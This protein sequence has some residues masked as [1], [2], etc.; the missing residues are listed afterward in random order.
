MIAVLRIGP[1]TD[2]VVYENH[3]Q[4][5]GL[6]LT[7]GS[8]LT[9]A[10]SYLKDLEVTTL[11]VLVTPVVKT[12]FKHTEDLPLFEIKTPNTSRTGYMSI[13]DLKQVCGLAYKLNIKEVEIF[14]L[15][16]VFK[17]LAR[18]EPCIVVGRYNSSNQIY[19]LYLDKNG[20]KD[21]H[22]SKQ[23]TNKNV[24]DL[25]AKH[26]TRR[27]INEYNSELIGR[28]QS[29]FTNL[30]Q[31][32]DKD[33]NYLYP[34]MLT[35]LIEPV[36]VAIPTKVLKIV[37]NEVDNLKVDDMEIP[38]IDD[39]MLTEEE[40]YSTYQEQN[41]SRF[42]SNPGRKKSNT[43]SSDKASEVVP[44]S[45]LK[46]RFA[47]K[48][49]DVVGVGLAM[50]M[51]VSLLGNKEIPKNIVEAKDKIS[52]LEQVVQPRQDNAKY[53]NDFNNKLKNGGTGESELAKNISG[54]KVDGMFGEIDFNRNKID[55]TVYFKNADDIESY[56]KSLSKYMKVSDITKL[57]TLGK[58]DTKLQ[59]YSIV[60]TTL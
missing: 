51:A 50:L 27:V 2:L 15:F 3:K 43:P 40:P 45:V 36:E 34:L 55:L 29:I 58:G 18:R 32:P 38:D 13:Y 30:E 54:I 4:L 16:D 35:D 19:Y 23:I 21:M 48:A 26:G 12:T 10:Y 60:G 49:L 17:L 11:R 59:K 1:S 42:K 22:L 39:D 7:E 25:I 57:S 24:A 52:Q 6:T 41:V 14:N 31:V 44:A 37:D 56:K 5:L 20:I 53:L 9:E 8:I 46:Q 28:V 33:I 47:C